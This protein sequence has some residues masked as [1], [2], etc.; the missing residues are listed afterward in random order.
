MKASHVLIALSLLSS[1]LLSADQDQN[2][3]YDS[4]TETSAVGK[5]AD[6]LEAYL[7][8]LKRKE[9][10]YDYQKIEAESSLL[11]DSWIQ[12]LQV[13]YRYSES[14]PYGVDQKSESA[15]IVMDQPI[16]QS[17]GI[18]FGIK[19]AEASQRYSNFSVDQQ[20]RQLIKQAVQL[21]MQIR[22][23]ELRIEKQELQIENSNIALKQKQEEYLN[24]QL[25]SGFLNNAVIETNLVT[26][27]LYDLET[28]KERLVS[29]F[30]SISDL[31]YTQA[32]VPFL[33]FMNEKEF[34]ERNIDLKLAQ[35]EIEKNRYNKNVTIAK[36]L[37]KV[38]LT[39][40]YN[41][42]KYDK[43]SFGATSAA[44]GAETDYASYGFKAS[45]PLDINAFRDVEAARVDYLKSKVLI[46]DRKRELRALFEQV[47][48]NLKN[49]DKKIELAKRNEGLYQE[50]LD[51]TKTLFEAG[52]KT[53]YDVDTL[54]NSVKIQTVDRQI[55]EMDKQLE[56]L[57]LYEKVTNDVQ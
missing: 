42:E 31:D 36:Y 9:F 29:Q 15:A 39:A 8:E 25:D 47:M 1:Q 16:F 34:M 5:P 46:D 22:Q 18:Y 17:G 55:F 32:R 49:Y 54:Q 43:K 41:W 35:S 51:E 20:K 44:P 3:S 7:S 27:A 38:S 19:F 26:Q 12:P 23:S 28:T 4:V 48:Q 24:G 13:Q 33:R 56:L 2:L 53:Q 45:M 10:A 14:D 50:L 37:P 6:E 52:Y 57:D 11:R 40:S 30:Q 21:L